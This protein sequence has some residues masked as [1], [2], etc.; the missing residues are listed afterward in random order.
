MV[1]SWN[2]RVFVYPTF[3]PIP[4]ANCHW[5]LTAGKLDQSSL[6]TEQLTLLLLQKSNHS[7]GVLAGLY[8]I[9]SRAKLDHL[10]VAKYYEPN[11]RNRF[12]AEQESNGLLQILNVLCDKVDN[13][14]IE[15]RHSNSFSRT[16]FIQLNFSM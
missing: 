11:L 5:T 8:L 13:S 6:V 10:Q 15:T 4:S 7:R 12:V 14:S 3:P 2:R 9:M 16:Q 1:C